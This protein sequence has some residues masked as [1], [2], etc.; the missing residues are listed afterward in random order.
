MSRDARDRR[1]SKRNDVKVRLLLSDQ[2]GTFG[3][4]TVD[5]SRGG[6]FASTSDLR[7]VGTL[8][9]LRL[10]NPTTEPVMAV[11]VVVRAFDNVNGETQ[12]KKRGLALALTSTSEGWDRYWDG[13]EPTPDAELDLEGDEGEEGAL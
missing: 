5:I 6:V 4:N 7:P 12:G 11:G 1:A 13:M 8:L 3:G 10:A 9:R 2:A